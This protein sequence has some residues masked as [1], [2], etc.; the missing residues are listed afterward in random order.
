MILIF[1]RWYDTCLY[2]FSCYI[3]VMWLTV[4]WNAYLF[5]PKWSINYYYYYVMWYLTC[6]IIRN[7]FRKANGT[8]DTLFLPDL[9]TVEMVTRSDN[10]RRHTWHSQL[11][12]SVSIVSG[13]D[14]CKVYHYLPLARSIYKLIAL[15]YVTCR[16]HYSVPGYF[17]I[18]KDLPITSLD[19]CPIN[20]HDV[21]IPL[22]N[23][24][25]NVY[26]PGVCLLSA[27]R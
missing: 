21:L 24:S 13:I 18:I 10:C 23:I 14:L 4:L 16:L 26:C 7:S 11:S 1:L 27:I 17:N 20:L 25:I 2:T 15:G 3:C 8:T 12:Q 19:N 22:H 6:L 9:W 5:G